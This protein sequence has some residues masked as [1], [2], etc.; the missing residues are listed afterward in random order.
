[1]DA[2][3]GALGEK[4]M[5]FISLLF[6][7]ILLFGIYI[8]LPLGSLLLIIGIILFIKNKRNI[9][10]GKNLSKIRKVIVPILCICGSILFF[11]GMLACI[12]F[13]LIINNK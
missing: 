1:V 5:A 6:I 2:R 10:R 4:N 11:L 12:I 7:Y 13:F 3:T 8:N 9:N